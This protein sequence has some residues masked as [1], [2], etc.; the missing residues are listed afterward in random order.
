MNRLLAARGYVYACVLKKP[1]AFRYEGMNHLAAVSELAML[2]AARRGEN[3]ELAGIAG[4]FHDFSVYAEDAVSDHAHKSAAA[5]AAW[6]KENGSFSREETE[7]VIGAVY[8]HSDKKMK[9]LPLDEILKDA[10]VAA[11]VLEHPGELTERERSRWNA[12]KD[13]LMLP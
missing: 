9:H 11:Y 3:T 12:L 7:Q 8:Y 6:M 2:L 1:S 13:E 5:A 10:D 4:I